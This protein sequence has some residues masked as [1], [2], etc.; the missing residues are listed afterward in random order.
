MLFVYGSLRRGFH[1]HSYLQGTRFFGEGRT[2]PEFDLVDL[3]DFPAMVRPGRF[4]VQG[5]IY[6]V[7]RRTLDEVDL[8]EGNGIFYER[9]A[10]MIF[11][12]TGEVE[13]WLYVLIEPDTGSKPIAPLPDGVTKIW[14]RR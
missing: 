8:V 7:N 6:Q 12:R 5:E 9:I 10:E 14:R 3:G 13:C 1:N 2:R 11:T 4:H